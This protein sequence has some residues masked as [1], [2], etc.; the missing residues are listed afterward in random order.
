MKISGGE[1]I[2]GRRFTGPEVGLN[3]VCLPNKQEAQLS[4][5]QDHRSKWGGQRVQNLV[6]SGENL[7]FTALSQTWKSTLD[8]PHKYTSHRENQRPIKDLCSQILFQKSS[9]AHVRNPQVEP[10]SRKKAVWWIQQDWCP[11]KREK[12]MEDS[13]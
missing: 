12:R 9:S 2:P 7:P 6:K 1:G 3:L 13:L 8:S 4:E 5:R 11:K 10:K